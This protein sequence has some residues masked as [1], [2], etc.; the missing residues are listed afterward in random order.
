MATHEKKNQ[1][2]DKRP[3]SVP[4]SDEHHGTGMPGTTD[5]HHGTG[6]PGTEEHHGTSTPAE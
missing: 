3:T 6:G 5:E 2:N 1:K 4:G